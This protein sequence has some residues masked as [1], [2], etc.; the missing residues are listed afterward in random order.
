VLHL[1][2]LALE[3]VVQPIVQDAHLRNLAVL[4]PL[5]RLDNLVRSL[6]ACERDVHSLHKS[7]KTYLVLIDGIHLTSLDAF[8]YQPDV[9]CTA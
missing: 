3:G 1:G 6:Y 8:I 2:Q 9:S 5:E 7:Q 4:L